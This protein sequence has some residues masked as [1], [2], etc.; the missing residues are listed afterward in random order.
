MTEPSA[1][2]NLDKVGIQP[3]T[4]IHKG[5]SNHI[6]WLHRSG[7]TKKKKGVGISSKV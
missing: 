6:A 5:S 4:H 7:Q 2:N 3:C 1:P